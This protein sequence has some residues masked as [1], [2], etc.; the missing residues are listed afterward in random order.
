[1]GRIFTYVFLSAF[2]L[3][4]GWQVSAQVSCQY[5]LQLYDSFG[6][7]W[8]GAV[9]TVNVGGT[10]TPYTLSPGGGASFQEFTLTVTAG[11]TL[12]LSYT[13]GSWE[14]EVSYFLLDGDGNVVFSAGPNPPVGANIFETVII[15]PACPAPPAA[16]VSIDDIRAFYADISWTPADPNGQ[17]LIEYGLAGFSPGTGQQRTS[18]GSSLRLQPLLQYTDYEFY[19]RAACSGGDTSLYRGPFAFKTRRAYDVGVVDA[20]VEA[21]DCDLYGV[22]EIALVMQNFGGLPQTFIPYNFTVNGVPGGV[23]QPQDGFFTG[24]MG[25]DSTFETVFETTYN[26]STPG[27]YTIQVFTQ[28]SQDTNYVNDTLTFSITTAP[29]IDELPYFEGFEVYNGGW[30]VGPQSQNPS[31]KHGKPAGALISAAASGNNAWVTN[32]AGN[33]NSGELSYLV[34]PCM[35]FSGLNQDPRISFSLRVQTEACCDELWLESSTDGGET[36]TKVGASGSGLNW[37]NDNVNQ[38]W[39]GNGGFTGWV[40]AVNVLQGTAGADQVR[41]RFVFSSDFSVA[42][43]GIGIDN[44][45]ISPQVAVD[46]ASVTASNAAGNSCGIPNDAVT[47]NLINLG[48][49]TLTTFSVAYQVN[50]GAIVNET[51]NATVNPGQ[52]YPYTF[53]TPFNSS[54]PGAYQV[55]VWSNLANDGVLFNDTI[56]FVFNSALAFPNFQDFESGGL[57]PNWTFDTDLFVTNGHNNTSFVLYDNLYSADQTMNFASPAF[58]P[59]QAGDVLYFEYRYSLWSAG[60]APHTLSGNDKLVVS[61]S[62]DCGQNYTDLYTIDANN[63]TPTV[64]MTSVSIPL[65][66]YLGQAVKVRFVGTWGSGDYWLDIDNIFLQRCSGL[67]LSADITDATGQAAGDGAVTVVHGRPTGPFTYQWSNGAT[68]RTVTSLNPGIYTVTVTDRFGCQDVLTAVVDVM[69][70][71]SSIDLPLGDILLA[72]NP[73]VGGSWLNI[74]LRESSDIQIRVFNALGQQLWQS[75]VMPNVSRLRQEIALPAAAQGLYFV[76]IQDT[77][78]KQQTI[79]WIRQ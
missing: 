31:W 18:S 1:M 65:D 15:C 13:P 4:S 64:D 48:T 66:S 33:Y 44:I 5:N 71:A 26:F 76:R 19:L 9:L 58:G 50:G 54:A 34:S 20:F 77:T 42:A 70:N 17:T 12:R 45:L 68:T 60:T 10:T 40:T 37:Y 38:W 32:L 23:S 8:N 57:P 51:V 63:H 73:S 3:L 46:L 7:G 56:T 11:D 2:L 61:I 14:N 21:V 75:A 74:E 6:D 79:R 52:S 53:V 62:T 47:V 35:D 25:V 69:V 39:D 43:E 30:T 29:F 67:Q 24:V 72:P 55:A 22:E 36:W 27:E 49:D 78:G 59:V 41:L 16:D 28:L